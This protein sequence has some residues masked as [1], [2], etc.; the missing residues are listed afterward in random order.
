MTINVV[1]M[2]D[3]R[4]RNSGST[5]VRSLAAEL[6]ALADELDTTKNPLAQ[7]TPVGDPITDVFERRLLLGRAGCLYFANQLEALAAR[8]DK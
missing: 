3:V 4:G 6:L 2:A 1:R 8:L 7:H 5:D